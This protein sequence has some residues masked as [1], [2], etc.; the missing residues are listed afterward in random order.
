[1]CLVAVGCASLCS[2]SDEPDD[3]VWCQGGKYECLV[4][5]NGMIQSACN[6]SSLW[7]TSSY[8][9]LIDTCSLV[10]ITLQFSYPVI[11]YNVRCMYL[12]C[13]YSSVSLCLCRKDR[14]RTPTVFPH[15]CCLCIFCGAL[16]ALHKTFSCR[17]I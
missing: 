2:R 1:M 14:L 12:P 17:R 5:S 7:C 9:H 10:A 11:S 15:A 6:C 3:V 4:C 13:A 8:P 16:C